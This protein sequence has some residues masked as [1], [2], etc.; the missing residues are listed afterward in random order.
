MSERS[1]RVGIDYDIPSGFIE[2]EI[3]GVIIVGDPGDELGFFIKRS[4]VGQTQQAIAELDALLSQFFQDVKVT[5]APTEGV[6]NY[7]PATDVQATGT[8]QGQPCLITIR[9]LQLADDALVAVMGA[10]VT[11]KKDHWQETADKFLQSIR[12]A[13]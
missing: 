12:R 8:F 11:Q 7:L 5:G 2:S 1:T 3:D 13:A 10:V 6:H 4:A 9:W